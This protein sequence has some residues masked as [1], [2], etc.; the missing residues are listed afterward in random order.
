MHVEGGFFDDFG[1]GREMHPRSLV[2][3]A[4]V[5]DSEDEHNNLFGFYATDNAM[6]A[7]AIAPKP[8]LVGQ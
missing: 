2:Y 7:D 5:P 4:S 1:E 3:C 6:I 8:R